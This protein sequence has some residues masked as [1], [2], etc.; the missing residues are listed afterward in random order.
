MIN[1]L[2]R[3]TGIGAVVLAA[4]TRSGDPAPQP[5]AQV[6]SCVDTTAAW[7][8]TQRE[9][10]NESGRSW[11]NDS[12]RQELLRVTGVDPSRLDVQLGVVVAGRDMAAAAT[13]AMAAA[14]AELRKLPRGTSGGTRSAVGP[15]GFRAYYRLALAD[16]AYSNGALHRMMEAGPEESLS[17][18]VATLEDAIRLRNGRKQIYGTQFVRD[19]RGTIRL[20]SMED[21]AHADL[22]REGAGLPPFPVSLCVA[23]ASR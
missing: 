14:I 23:K 20:A 15:A 16:S 7:Y 10:L 19:D 9:W 3:I 17:A 8:R 4:G 2:T 1:T 13:P 6:S 11:T 5:N 22:R 21:S 18:D 12:L